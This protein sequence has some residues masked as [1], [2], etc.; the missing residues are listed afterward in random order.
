MIKG[1]ILNWGLGKWT[2]DIKKDEKMEARIEDVEEV[3]N[4]DIMN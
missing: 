1:L 4:K 3:E 2:W